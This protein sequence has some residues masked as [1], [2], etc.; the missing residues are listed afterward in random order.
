MAIHLKRIV[1]F[2]CILN[3]GLG[4]CL[5]NRANADDPLEF[6]LYLPGAYNKFN[7]ADV[8]H[9]ISGLVFLVNG[10]PLEN[11]GIYL[12]AIENPFTSTNSQGYY[13]FGVDNSKS[14]TVGSITRFLI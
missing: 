10:N 1:F 2:F 14:A 5:G 7:I 8:S 11:V 13:D 12:D 3:F 9:K 4:C 6:F